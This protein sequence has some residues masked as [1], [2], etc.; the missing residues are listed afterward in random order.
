M[1]LTWFPQ[2]KLQPPVLRTDLIERPRLLSA[3]H[4]QLEHH[5]LILLSAPAGYGKTTL[6]VQWLHQSERP[7]AWLSLD[8]DDNDP[9][10]FVLLLVNALQTLHTDVGKMALELLESQASAP[11][12]ASTM[13]LWR[14]MTALLINDILTYLP[15]PFVLLFDDV[16]LVSQPAI[17][18]ALDYLLDN[19]PPQMQLIMTTRVDPPLA[20]ARLRVRGRVA[21]LRL[22]DLRFNNEEMVA[23]LGA[24]QADLGQLESYTEGWPAALRLLTMARQRTRQSKDA[25]LNALGRSG[26]YLF[27]FL[28]REV[29]EEQ[30]ASVRT[31]LL[32]TSIL[33]ELDTRLC[34]AVTG[35]EEHQVE[36]LLQTLYQRNLFLTVAAG[37]L[38]DNLLF[39]RPTYRYHDLFAHFLRR[40]LQQE[41]P[42]EVAQLYRRAAL[43]ATPPE[44]IR[45]Y[46]QAQ[47]Y[48]EASS[49]IIQIGPDYVHRG[50]L[51][52][53]TGWLSAIPETK[54]QKSAWLTL[55]MGICARE[56]QDFAMAQTLFEQAL[57]GF[58]G[59]EEELHQADVYI[60]LVRLA[61]FQG[62]YE[63]CVL[64][65]N[66]GLQFPLH[67]EPAL[68]AC[69]LIQRCILLLFPGSKKCFPQVSRDLATVYNLSLTNHTLDMALR[70]IQFGGSLL[71]AVPQGAYYLEAIDQQMARHFQTGNR[72]FDYGFHF[73]QAMIHLWRGRLEEAIQA[74]QDGLAIA[75]DFLG[76]IMNSWCYFYPGVI[77]TIQGQFQEAISYFTQALNTAQNY[78]GIH[79]TLSPMY[80]SCFGRCLLL[81]GEWQK[82]NQVYLLIEAMVAKSEFP[83]IKV[84]PEI[85]ACL[86]LIGE[87]KF[88]QAEAKLSHIWHVEEEM[89]L[90]KLFGSPRTMLAVVYLETGRLDEALAEFTPLLAESEQQNAP[91]LIL[92]ESSLV[93]PLLRLAIARQIHAPFASKLLTM[94]G[95]D[96]PPS[97]TIPETG[98]QLTPRELE[99]LHLIAQGHTNRQLAEQLVVS[100]NTVRTHVSH[101][102]RKLNVTTRTQAV[103]RARELRLIA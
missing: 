88:S 34:A 77:R 74:C 69:L 90:V 19:I 46:L 91:Y 11:Q 29:L 82:A 92:K 62:D 67:Q 93:I 15:K 47:A 68:Q 73:R 57:V 8:E 12:Q 76:I 28:A 71:L 33:A 1:T 87:K 64:Y 24:E 61:S 102:L 75:Q 52:T 31:F 66:Q 6:L 26:Q 14:Q 44:A 96:S 70:A 54:L 27:D 45:Y 59:T 101:I 97:A 35:Q 21:E 81:A 4:K 78:P 50:M 48:D 103:A 55:F 16:H 36:S 18:T 60:E 42:Q 99:V 85:M 39:A 30:E 79:T 51:E 86:L 38:G 94:M 80:L 72:L 58:A 23:F 7:F 83:M 22:A 43:K 2:T 25:L 98:E 9:V 40:Q 10:R 37:T 95:S 17:F 3:L 84:V 100:K 56:R 13:R 5:L 32:Q 53:L 20:L 65:V 89:P 63:R 41:R 49:L